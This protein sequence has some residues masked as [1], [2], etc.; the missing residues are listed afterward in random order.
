MRKSTPT[1]RVDAPTQTGKMADLIQAIRD[2]ASPK[3]GADLS[4]YVFGKI[5][6]QALAIEEAVLGAILSEKDAFLKVDFLQ[7]HHFYL[8]AH[9]LVYRACHRLNTKGK[10]IDILTI[11]EEL[12]H[13]GELESIGG[14]Y[15]LTELCNRVGS[16]AN[17]EYHARIIY[18]KWLERDLIMQCC[19]TI[20]K[21]YDGEDTFDLR[22]NH[23]EK[24]AAGGYGFQDYFRVRDFNKVMKDA[25]KEPEML[26]LAGELLHMGDLMM[27]FAQPGVGKTILSIQI[28]NALARGEQI[29]QNQLINEAQGVKLTGV[30]FDFEMFDKELQRRYQNEYS[31]GETYEWPE[32]LK[33]VDINPNF[34]DFPEGADIAKFK[35]RQIEKIIKMERPDFIVIDNVTALAGAGLSDP[36]EAERL[37]NK[38][39]GWRRKFKSTSG[40]PLTVIV[41]AHTTKRYNKAAPI[42]LSNMGGAAALGNFASS[43]AAIGQSANDPDEFYIKQLK[44][45]NKEAYGERNVIVCQK[46]KLNDTFLAYQFLR[47]DMESNLLG[48]FMEK[49]SQDDMLAE[50]CALKSQGMS[51]S[52]IAKKI[53]WPHSEESLRMKCKAYLDRTGDQYEFQKNGDIVATGQAAGDGDGEPRDDKNLPF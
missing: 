10:P 1:A 45:R 20:K 13:T 11:S 48:D 40:S 27:L 37:M 22:E 53:S 29:I 39:N 41:I 34:D 4:N 38:M 35:M 8:D 50:A 47:Y 46:T 6:P 52:K 43:V 12:R 23:I 25:A 14:A 3:K 5:Q 16:S 28:A 24:V 42:E 15:Y 36:A 19:N 7:D 26:Q 44:G 51:F 32:S 30:Y 2:L 9:Q 21:A 49:H 31:R 17:I 18:Q 33:R